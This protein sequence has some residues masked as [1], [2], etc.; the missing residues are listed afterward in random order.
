MTADEARD[1]V[2]YSTWASRRLLDAALKLDAEQQHRDVG[3]SH[4]SVHATLAHILSGDRIWLSRIVGQPIEPEGALE[5]EWPEIGRRW[6]QLAEG[7]NDSDLERV[8]D[9]KQSSG[10]EFDSTVREIVLHVVNHATLHRGQV[11]AIFRQLGIAP[12]PTDLIF[13][14]REQQSAHA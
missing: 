12:P 4:K 5:V 7:W 8:V 6:E 13:Y 1:H 14:Y 10:R 11:M 9:Y 2:R 3:V